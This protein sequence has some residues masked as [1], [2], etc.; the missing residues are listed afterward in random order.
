MKKQLILS[1]FLFL[2][3]FE[4]FAQVPVRDEDGGL[5]KGKAQKKTVMSVPAAVLLSFKADHDFYLTVDDKKRGDKIMA[6]KLE[7]IKLPVGVH[8]LSFEEADS[9]GETQE[10]Y[11]RLTSEMAK[12][13]DSV[14]SISFKNDFQA[15]MN[16]YPSTAMTTVSHTASSDQDAQLKAVAK[17]LFDSMVL[18]QG[19]SFT[20]TVKSGQKTATPQVVTVRSLYVGK[21][22]VTQRQWQ[23]VMGMNSNSQK[24]CTDCPVEGVSWN[25]V[26]SF[27]QKLNKASGKKF[28]LPTEMEWEYTAKKCITEAKGWSSEPAINDQIFKTAAGSSA[29]FE[30]R[31]AHKVGEKQP[32][33]GLYDLLGNV[34]EWCA[35]GG[36]KKVFKGGSYKSKEEELRIAAR[37]TA[38]PDDKPNAVGFRLVTDTD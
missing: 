35:D 30:Q 1:L 33:A 26:N 12:Q 15:I 32:L 10:R 3:G 17:E 37:S 4:C 31:T 22:E 11:F 9:T 23:A 18:I 29:W 2:V 25:E 24:N 27:I 21:Y 16:A 28:R 34:A 14:F 5:K 19:G 38:R 8:K 13:K 7:S 6:N 20:T 36:D